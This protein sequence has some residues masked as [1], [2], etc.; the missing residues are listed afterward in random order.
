MGVCYW[1]LR[2]C[3]KYQLIRTEVTAQETVSIDSTTDMANETE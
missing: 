2:T 1:H 3:E